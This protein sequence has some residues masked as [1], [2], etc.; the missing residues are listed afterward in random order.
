MSQNASMSQAPVSYASEPAL[1]GQV[2]SSNA[3]LHTGD[4]KADYGADY[5]FEDDF[6]S[7]ADRLMDNIFA[8]VER[9]LER[10]VDLAD[11][12]ISVPDAS[13]PLQE[14]LWSAPAEADL[15]T[16]PAPKLSP[17]PSILEQAETEEELADLAALMAEVS[18]ATTPAK[19]P[20]SFDTLLLSLILASLVVTGGFWLYFRNRLQPAAVAVAPPSADQLKQ[21]KNQEFL[22]YVGRSLDRIERDAKTQRDAAAIAATGASPSPSPST[23]LERV[24]IPIY[25]TPPA[26]AAL[27]SPSVNL[28]NLAPPVPQTAPPAVASPAAPAAP[29]IAAASA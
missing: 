25:Q 4:N 7:V 20:R 1:A 11:E 22:Q 18:E 5:G 3:E 12:P 14:T 27:P 9:M 10:G 6:G 24:Y 2:D 21:Q 17:R 29:N 23:V 19:S 8:D 13:E 15:A 16:I 26:G 28:P